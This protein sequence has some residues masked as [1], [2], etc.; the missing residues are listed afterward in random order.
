MDADAHSLDARIAARIAL[1]RE[2]RAWTVAELAARSGV[3]R[4]MISKI[5]K[6]EVRP[7]ASLLGRLAAAFQTPLS[8]LLASVED[9]TA[10]VSP[11]AVQTVWKDPDTGYIRRA[12]SPPSDRV[13]QLT[14]IDLPP[15]RRVA[16]PPAVFAHQQI[17]VLEGRLTFHEGSATTELRSGDCLSMGEPSHCVFE[18]KSS[19]RCQYL[20]ALVQR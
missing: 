3:S 12:L 5:E 20:L 11:H 2:S 13:L 6:G 16:F 18:N 9:G 8:L 17:W 15:R 7:T 4:A 1:E 19:R 10:R 14:L